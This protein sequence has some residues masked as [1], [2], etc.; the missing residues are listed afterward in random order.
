MCKCDKIIGSDIVLDFPSVGATENIILTS[1][2]CKGKTTIINAAKEPEILDLCNMLNRMGAKI[3]C[4]GS[5]KIEV[6][7]V[8][9]LKD[10]EYKI[11]PDRIEACTLLCATAT[12]GGNITL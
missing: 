12:T 4:G 8:K 6:E 3:R 7:G 1:V 10:I 2:F 5:N 9:K 11:I